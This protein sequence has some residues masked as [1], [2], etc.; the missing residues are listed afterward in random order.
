MWCVREIAQGTIACGYFNFDQID[1]W[2]N[3][4]LT[5]S[6]NACVNSFGLILAP[7]WDPIWSTTIPKTKPKII[8][9]DN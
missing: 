3:G 8:A 6:I 1:L 4:E 7:A 9:L 5:H 2:E